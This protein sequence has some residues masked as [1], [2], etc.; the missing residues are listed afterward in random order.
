[1]AR[2]RLLAGE[3]RLEVA[4]RVRVPAVGGGRFVGV[5]AAYTRLDSLLSAMMD[6]RYQKRRP[7]TYRGLSGE[8]DADIGACVGFKS[9]RVHSL[10]EA[11]GNRWRTL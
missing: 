3:G 7:G 8:V 4:W 11:R 2:L 6:D 1:M 5:V 10:A 9:R